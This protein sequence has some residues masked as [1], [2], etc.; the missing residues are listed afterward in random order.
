MKRKRHT[1]EQIIGKLRE[2]DAALAKGGRQDEGSRTQFESS[3]VPV[4]TLNANRETVRF[5]GIAGE[6]LPPPGARWGAE[7]VKSGRRC[8]PAAI[9]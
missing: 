8:C 2:A 5:D 7:V 4:V 1:P 6:P 9:T 3:P